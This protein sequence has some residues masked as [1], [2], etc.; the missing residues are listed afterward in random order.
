MR[1]EFTGIQME[2]RADVIVLHVCQEKVRDQH[3]Q[4][5][6]A[7]SLGKWMRELIP[8]RPGLEYEVLFGAPAETV[9]CASYNVPGRLESMTRTFGIRSCVLRSA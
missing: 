7:E 5:L 1:S 8:P 4:D 9:S 2:N 3:E 6:A